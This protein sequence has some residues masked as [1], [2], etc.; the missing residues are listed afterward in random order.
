MGETVPRRWVGGEAVVEAIQR[1]AGIYMNNS[2]DFYYNIGGTCYFCPYLKPNSRGSSGWKS[3][4]W[5]RILVLFSRFLHLHEQLLTGSPANI[6]VLSFPSPSP[7]IIVKFTELF[8]PD[9][10]L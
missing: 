3:F 5:G 4:G 8:C 6:G 2:S 7:L 10:Y 1:E 9:R